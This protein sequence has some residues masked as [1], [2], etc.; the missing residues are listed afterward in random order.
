MKTSGLRGEASASGLAPGGFMGALSP[1]CC[2]RLATALPGMACGW[3]T[4]LHTMHLHL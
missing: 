1:E 3:A 4:S 2:K